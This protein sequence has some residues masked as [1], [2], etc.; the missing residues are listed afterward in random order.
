[1]ILN[2]SELFYIYF[3]LIKP[4]EIK[5]KLIINM[6]SNVNDTIKN[7]Y[8]SQTSKIDGTAG[9]VYSIY[10]DLGKNYFAKYGGSVFITGIVVVIIIITLLY[11]NVKKNLIYIKDNWSEL[12]CDPRY[13]PFAGMVINDDTKGFFESGTENANYCF[14]RVLHEVSEDAMMPYHS[15]MNVY[16][17]LSQKL[18][19][20]GND[21]RNLTTTM[22]ENLKDTFKE[23]YGRIIN[24]VIPIQK[25]LITIKDI[26]AKTKGAMVTSIYPMLGLY[27]TLK[28]AIDGVYNLIVKILIGLAATI[29]V[30]W[31][32]P[33]TWGAAASMTAIFIMIMIPMVILSSMMGEIFHLSPKGLP[34]KPSRHCF[35]GDFKIETHRGS[36]PINKLV[37]GDKI[38]N[39]KI[40]S[41]MKLSAKEETMYD[42]GSGLLVSGRHKIFN[43]AINNF[44]DVSVDGRF[45]PVA[46][47]KDEYIY[48]FNTSNKIIRINEH[49]FLDYDELNNAELTKIISE[50]KKI[51]KS[52]DFSKSN[53][54]RAFDG[55]FYPYT[56]VMAKYGISKKINEIRIGEELDSGNKVLGI[57]YTSNSIGLF[58][59]KI[60]NKQVLHGVNPNIIYY[61][62]DD[63]ENT[64]LVLRK[65]F[66]NNKTNSQNNIHL[67]TTKGYFHIGNRKTNVKVGDYNKCIEYF[68]DKK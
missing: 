59:V 12:K 31:I 24:S 26:M 65:K 51:Y 2:I 60:N 27:F 34:K 14:N 11:I 35:N 9:K 7:I 61:D 42:L 68:I 38:H 63:N 52:I 62:E 48:C 17:Q 29:V 53:I 6:S 16:N 20:I 30:L 18:L 66:F 4:S 54:H 46:S 37:P 23:Q 50:Y 1:M 45:T 32:F 36:V 25:M 15:I 10:G 57:V 41:V 28:S 40:T 43:P 56:L 58:N 3:I 47:F 49:V 22:R 55:G 5:Y 44:N 19:T 13:A 33:F 64:T 21:I 39:V 8:N 67:L